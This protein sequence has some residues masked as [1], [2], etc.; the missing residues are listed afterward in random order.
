MAELLESTGIQLSFDWKHLIRATL[1]GQATM[2]QDI[3]CQMGKSWIL[4]LMHLCAAVMGRPM[5]IS[6]VVPLVNGVE[7]G[8][9]YKDILE[10]R[11]VLMCCNVQPSCRMN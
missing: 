11:D 7:L 3:D 10:V 1:S 4:P 6:S 9:K 5:V 8:D 2:T